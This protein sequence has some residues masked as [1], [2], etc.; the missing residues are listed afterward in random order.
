MPYFVFSPLTWLLPLVLVLCL[1]W[2]RLPRAARSA[3]VAGAVVLV[4]ACT[5]AGANSLLWL[6][7]SRVDASDRCPAGTSA[8]W[9][10]LSGGFAYGPG[11]V[12]EYTALMPESW[13][14]LRVGVEAWR[15]D[16]QGE[17]WI[18]GGGPF[19]VSEAGLLG[20]LAGEWGIPE[21]AL[22]LETE[23]GNT[24]DGARA[25]RGRLPT[26]VRIVTSSW[27]QARS[28]VAFRAAG[29]APCAF[30]TGS[31]LADLVWPW[32]LLPQGAAVGK[33]EGSL[34]ELVGLAAYRARAVRAR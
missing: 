2:R 19:R 16:G 14:R 28:L 12:D 22:R 24:W 33:S 8:P 6:V 4:L 15:R 30:D 27:H 17:F 7:E 11:R 3:G 25:L 29:F 9:V 10:V 26:Q 31:E 23:S 18:A 34:Y 20:A 1:A 5:P 13:R 32:A 21:S